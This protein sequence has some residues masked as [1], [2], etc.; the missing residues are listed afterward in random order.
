MT[1]KIDNH[2]PIW[3]RQLRNLRNDLQLITDTEVAAGNLE[4]FKALHAKLNQYIAPCI[5][6][7]ES[8]IKETQKMLI[9]IQEARSILL[10]IIHLLL[11]ERVR[12]RFNDSSA[13]LDSYIT[14]LSADL[15]N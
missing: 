13:A 1:T 12:V 11:T 2:S 14:N 7:I 5:E 10:K 6:W 8:D 3:F 9:L 15:T 4:E